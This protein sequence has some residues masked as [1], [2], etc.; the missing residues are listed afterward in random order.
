M[1]GNFACTSEAWLEATTHLVYQRKTGRSLR[2]TVQRFVDH[3]HHHYHRLW[4]DWNTGLLQEL[5]RH[6]DSWPASQ[7]IPKC[8]K[9]SLFQ[10][11]YS[12]PRCSLDGLAF[13]SLWVRCQSL[14]CDTGQ[15][16]SEGVSSPSLA[17]LEDFIF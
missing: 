16:L 7:V 6:P 13:S 1:S 15:W 11:P 3:S 14:T 8:N 5:S 4:P 9:T 10:P 17:S 12:G 2:Q